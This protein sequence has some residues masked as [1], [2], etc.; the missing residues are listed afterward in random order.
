MDKKL[1][2]NI[3][4]IELKSKKTKS[5]SSIDDLKRDLKYLPTVLKLF[6]KIDIE[7][8]IIGDNQFKII[9]DEDTLY[10]DNKFV[11]ISSKI[12]VSSK[13]VSFDLYSLY[14]KDIELLFDGKIKVDYFS[15]K[16]N[17]FGTFYYQDIKSNIN[18]DMTKELAKFYLASESFKSLKFLKKFIK[19]P[20]TAEEWMYDNVEGNIKLQDFYGEF[21]LQKNEIILDSLQGKAQIEAAKIKFH[22]DL[23]V[24]NTKSLDITF[25][26]DNLGFNLI[27]PTFKD[28][29]LDGSFVMIHN[30]SDSTGEVE[31]NI[32][33]NTKLDKDILGILKAYKIDIPL[34]QKSGNT[35][36]SLQMIFPY[37]ENKPM[38]TKG[39]FLLS[40]AEVF[41]NKFAFSSKNAEVLL[42]NSIV[43]VKNADFKHKNMIDALV[44]ISIDTK[45]L[46]S[47]GTVDIKSFLIEKEDKEKI[48][49]IQN[50]KSAI[51]MDFNKEV[52]IEL[53]DLETSIKISDLV[54]V[55]IK[56][57]SKIYPYSKL[58]KDISIKDG[59]I[60]LRIKDDK[61]IDF[62]A[63]VKG[64]D[65]PIQR[66]GNSI[67]NLDITG[68]IQDKDISISSDDKSLKVEIRDDINIYLKDLDVLIDSKGKDNKFTNNMNIYLDNS[69]LKIDESIYQ[70]KNAK[71]TIKKD[72]ISFN[73]LVTGLDIPLKKNDKKIEELSIEGIYTKNLTTI[74][75]KNKDL[76]LE[77]KKDYLSVK[78]DG[79]DVFYSTQSNEEEKDRN[80]DIAG[81]NSNIFINEK[82]KVLADNYDISIR[83][84]KSKFIHLKHKK[85]DITIKESK[86]KSIDI[87][88][89]DISA[90]FINTI[91]AKKIF[92]GGNILFLANGDINNLNGKVLIQN[93]NIK[94]L[95]ILN[96]LLIF[97][98]TSPALINPF[99][100][101]PSVV[102]M[103]TNSGFNLTAYKIVNGSLDFNYSKDKELIDIKKLVTVGNGI[104]F[105]GKGKVNLKDMTLNS[106]IKLVFL[107]D[108]SK[109]VGS[110]PVINFVLLGNNNR[111]ETQVNIFGS[112]DNPKIST[113]LT[114]DAFSV[115]MN[116]AK[117]ILESPGMLFDFITGAETQEE[118]DN[119]EN[120]IN[121]PLQ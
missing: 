114:K 84:D 1:I 22:K 116:I 44:N 20:T 106:D 39:V 78:I 23:D 112:I 24:V 13:Q 48:V 56:N 10:L 118:K 111:V 26:N 54:Y 45:T 8:L 59:N 80:I 77:L 104:D 86:D 31:V 93:S 29:K 33:A 97:I 58:L 9:L 14:L 38:T 16:L 32:K 101:I 27:E 17:Y 49:H 18:V 40:D 63:N 7:R 100:A 113:N 6:Q 99:L 105:D 57:L 68:V 5:K 60:S 79:Y 102:G 75:T 108:Y 69:K 70:L 11:N 109:I 73:A 62:S 15:E 103:A 19:L 71:V 64:L 76:I 117:R 74:N 55:D 94:D 98:H 36:A 46:K 25:E 41:I 67:D 119:K 90:E 96:N 89:N 4:N 121:K 107:K 82:F 81:K 53:K 61:N 115:P 43:E 30:L 92:E 2:L 72:D 66:N 21:D 110:I 3:E 12:D 83:T 34:V 47:G 52:N 65:F 37:E 87:F 88:S 120:M 35:E 91:F 51:S 28:K 95:A 85:T 50:K 42:N